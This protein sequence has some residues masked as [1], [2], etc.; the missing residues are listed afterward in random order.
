MY[1][2]N[3]QGSLT[4]EKVTQQLPDHK[5]E[6]NQIKGLLLSES[7]AVYGVHAGNKILFTVIEQDN[8]YI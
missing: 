5:I 7:D 8:K 2:L 3:P 4:K 1:F 6:N